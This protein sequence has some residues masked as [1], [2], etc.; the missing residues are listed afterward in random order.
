MPLDK[1]IIKRHGRN[2][3]TGQIVDTYQRQFNSFDRE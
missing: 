1:A 3:C 2:W